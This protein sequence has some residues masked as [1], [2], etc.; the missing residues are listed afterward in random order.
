[1]HSICSSRAAPSMAGIARRLMMTLLPETAIAM[2]LC[3]RWIRLQR[4]RIASTSAP[5]FM[6][7]PSTID[8]GGTGSM[9]KF[10]STMPRRETLSWTSLIAL[11]PMSSPTHCLLMRG[12]PPFAE[13]R[14][15]AGLPELDFREN[16]FGGGGLKPERLEDLALGVHATRTAGLDPIDRQG[17]DSRAT[18]ELRLAHHRALPQLLDVVGVRAGLGS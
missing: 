18:S 11:V 9:P 7:T 13:G 1:S 15:D 6:I 4:L 12:R 17:T 10:C 2:P 8:C 14:R 5:W 3:F 16:V